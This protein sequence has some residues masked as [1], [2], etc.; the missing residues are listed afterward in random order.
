MKNSTKGKI[1]RYS[2]VVALDAGAPLAATCAYFPMWVNKGSEATVSGVFVVLA[3]LSLIP[4]LLVFK[5]KIKT[6]AVWVMWVILFVTLWGLYQIIEQM[7]VVA[8]VGAVSNAAGA[9]LYKVGESIEKSDNAPA[10]GFISPPDKK[11]GN[12]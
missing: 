12:G 2:S 9:G 3:L 1:I 10:T 7:L 8:A 6:P 4:I 5:Q 11:G